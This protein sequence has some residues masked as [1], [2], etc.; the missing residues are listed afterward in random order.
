M[1]D[2]GSLVG[3]GDKSSMDDVEIT[4]GMVLDTCHI[5]VS[6]GG[7]WLGDVITDNATIGTRVRQCTA[8]LR[9]Q[10][11]TVYTQG[12]LGDSI[13]LPLVRR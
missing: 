9:P 4:D 7:P 13:T 6:V 2:D 3:G 10:V 12:V 5:D 1:A 8:L 11:F